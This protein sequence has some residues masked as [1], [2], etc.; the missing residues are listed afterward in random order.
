MMTESYLAQ[1]L[2]KQ[3]SACKSEGFVP[4]CQ[5]CRTVDQERFKF[6]CSFQHDV[7]A[8][9]L[10]REMLAKN[11]GLCALHTWQYA[12]MADTRSLCISYSAVLEYW[13]EYLFQLTDP[14][15][16]SIA[17]IEALLPT[18]SSCSICEVCAHAEAE[19]IAV[20]VQQINGD[21]ATDS[22][23]AL[24]LRHLLGLIGALDNPV[25]ICGLLARQAR[26]LKRVAE[27]MKNYRSKHDKMDRD[28]INENEHRAA[29]SGVKL[30]AGLVNLSFV[31]RVK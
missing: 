7:V 31:R 22:I 26:Y 2:E 16:E 23:S 17:K 19:A 27:D 30:M 8:D 18:D 21:S 24:C 1:E 13:A 10:K 20:A 12:S 5:I 4:F 3:S 9:P 6:I 28:S 29:I 15:E 25:L 14:R 11:G